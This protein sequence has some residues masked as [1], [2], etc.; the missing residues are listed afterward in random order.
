M[1]LAKP[2]RVDSKTDFPTI[3]F[4]KTPLKHF[5]EL[6]ESFIKYLQQKKKS[7][8]ITIIEPESI[9]IKLANIVYGRDLPKFYDNKIS[10]LTQFI[11]KINPPDTG[12]KSVFI[13]CLC[14]LVFF[15][16][17]NIFFFTSIIRIHLIYS[18]F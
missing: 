2:L 1:S 11:N 3:I 8:V 4:I 12:T 10:V 16:S 13:N 9:N 18:I 14:E 17:I 5:S 6:K 15:R 7:D